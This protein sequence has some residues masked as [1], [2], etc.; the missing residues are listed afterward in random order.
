MRNAKLYNAFASLI[1]IC[2]GVTL[3]ISSFV[4]ERNE[5]VSNDILLLSKE[6]NMTFYDSCQDKGVEAGCLDVENIS[7]KCLHNIIQP[8]LDLE[9]MHADGISAAYEVHSRLINF[10]YTRKLDLLYKGEQAPDSLMWR[11]TILCLTNPNEWSKLGP[12]QLHI[13]KSAYMRLIKLLHNNNEFSASV[14]YDVMNF[15]DALQRLHHTWSDPK[16]SYVFYCDDP[17]VAH[18]FGTTIFQR[19]QKSGTCVINSIAMLQHCLIGK[20]THSE[21]VPIL[22]IRAYLRQAASIIELNAYLFDLGGYPSLCINNI[23]EEGSM[24]MQYKTEHINKELLLKSGPLWMH[25]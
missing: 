15:D 22:D 19:I 17:D 25:I 18:K 11:T 10:I 4:S 6:S 2:V 23:M 8:S 21:A 12:E 14:S 16:E 1:L 7:A 20:F 5:N 9:R 24:R 3:I 13:F